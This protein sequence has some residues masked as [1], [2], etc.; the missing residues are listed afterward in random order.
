VKRTAKILFFA[1]ALAL[2]GSIGNPLFPVGLLKEDPRGTG[3]VNFLVINGE[4]NINKFSFSYMTPV[5]TRGD[6]SSKGAEYK[7]IDFKIPVHQ[8][9]PGNPRMYNDFLSLL[10]A[11]EFPYIIISLLTENFSGE[12]KSGIS[13]DERIAVTIAGVTRE[14]TVDCALAHCNEDLVLNGMQTVRLTDFGLIPPV[15][16]SG[17]V[18]VENEINVRFGFIVNFTD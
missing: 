13:R 17:I 6:V 15:R 3:C 9:K 7:K 18:K 11:K 16:L 4:S 10:K 14:Y 12:E 8:F 2:C 1:S 5:L